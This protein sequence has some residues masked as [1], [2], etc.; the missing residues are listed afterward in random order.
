[1]CRTM[2]VLSRISVALCASL[3][4]GCIADMI[5]P[6]G[7]DCYTAGSDGE[8]AD[9]QPADVVNSPR[10]ASFNPNPTPQPWPSPDPYHTPDPCCQTP[11]CNTL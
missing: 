8:P 1:M 3:V 4:G 2:S 5:D 11:D 7:V 9:V 6:S 10:G